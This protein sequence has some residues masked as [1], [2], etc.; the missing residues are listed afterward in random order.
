[1][2]LGMFMGVLDI[3]IVAASLP[4]IQSAL[5]IPPEW[6]SWIQTAYLI[7]EVISIPL[8]GVLT[9]IFSMRGLFVGA[10]SV[11]T[12]ASLGCAV[13]FGFADL[14]V[15]RVIQG[16]AGGVLIPL[17]FAAV[18]L[19]FPF[20]TQGLATTIAGVLAVIAPTVGPVVGGWVTEVFSWHWLFLINIVPGIVAALVAYALLPRGK[21]DLS[22]FRRLD[23]T[24][25]VLLALTLTALE[26]ALKEGP[27]Q[28]WLS[29]LVVGLFALTIAAGEF[30]ALR[31]LRRADPIVHLRLL[32]DR[33][34]ALGCVLSFITG[35]GIYG[36]VYLMPVFLGFV[37]GYGAMRIGEVMLVCG[38]AQ[39]LAAPI[40]V[41]LERRM[42]AR[43]MAALGFLLFAVG[44]GLSAW[45]TRDTGYDEMFWPQVLRGIGMMFC[46]LPVI[47]LAVGHMPL[48]QVPDASG[49]FNLQRNLGG[50][51]G[52]ALIDTI[53][54]G[55]ARDYAVSLTQ[56][57]TMGERA[58]MDEL[59]IV[60]DLFAGTLPSLEQIT[61]RAQE[62][63]V[64]YGVND[65][66]LMLAV[67]V[68]AGLILLPFVRHRLAPMAAVTS[69]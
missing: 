63:A 66:W 1:M 31:T 24:S 12:V 49:L 7:A 10:I 17:V 62:A 68:G 42:D 69:H 64:I 59:Q 13:S 25:L 5:D 58:A 65:A 43:L 4:N 46:I 44:L 8:T 14:L 26:V 39:L 60:A 38:A 9:R 3:Q 61:R 20:R 22:L 16:A 28:G 34:F 11:F 35:I 40:G 57:A 51:I 54:F 23:W 67:I 33:D 50:A 36:S 52:L 29:G 15:W 55:H 32:G 53:L 37:H 47:R 41:A 6:M 21:P 18:F 56:R 30:F 48:E 27:L 19:L 2:C 45:Q